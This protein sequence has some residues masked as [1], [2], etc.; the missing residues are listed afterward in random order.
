MMSPVADR[1][2]G[3]RPIDCMQVFDKLPSDDPLDNL[4][5][6]RQVGYWSITLQVASIPV[7]AS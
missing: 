4:R 6:E 7:T 1:N 3:I 5:R 2:R